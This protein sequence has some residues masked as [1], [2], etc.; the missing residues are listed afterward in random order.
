MCGGAQNLC[1]IQLSRQGRGFQNGIGNH[2]WVSFLDFFDKHSLLV[3]KVCNLT[4]NYINPQYHLVF[5]DLFQTIFSN[6]TM[7]DVS[8]NSIYDELF[9]NARDWYLEMVFDGE[10]TIIYHSPALEDVWLTE[11][12]RGEKKLDVQLVRTL[13]EHARMLWNNK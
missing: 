4:T 3:A 7:E 13:I 9:D 11:V 10:G 8:A 6:K 2:S 12:A 5:D 1:W